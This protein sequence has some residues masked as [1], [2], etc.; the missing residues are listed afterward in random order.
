MQVF[1]ELQRQLHPDKNPQ[2]QEACFSRTDLLD[3]QVAF[4][5]LNCVRGG[6]PQAAKLAF[7][8]LMEN[9]LASRRV[10]EFR[11]GCA[12]YIQFA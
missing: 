5:L 4:G 6:M 9:R 2:E 3:L 8:K 1:K 11:F 10:H 12:A 7:Q